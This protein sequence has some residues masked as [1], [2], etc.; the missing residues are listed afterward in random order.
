MCGSTTALVKDN[1]RPPC[2]QGALPLACVRSR[3]GWWEYC[4]L[5]RIT[6]IFHDDASP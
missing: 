4:S 5:W 2:G 3:A 6:R 1:V